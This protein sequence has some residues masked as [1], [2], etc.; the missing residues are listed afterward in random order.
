MLT[1]N[2]AH[3]L[4]DCLDSLFEVQIPDCEILVFDDGSSDNTP[5]VCAAYERKDQRVRTCRQP[6]N[7]GMLRNCAAALEAASGRY[8]SVIADDDSVLPGNFEKK[9][10]ILDAHPEVGLVYSLF[11][12]TNEQNQRVAM[13]LRSEYMPYSYVGG[14]HEFM[15]LLSG[16]YVP[17]PSVVVRHTL[18]QRL[19]GHDASMPSTLSDWD[20]W[21]R[22]SHDMATAF[23]REPLVNVR[24]HGGGVSSEQASDMALSMIPVWRKWLVEN[25]DPP[26]V[27]PRTWERMR[28]MFF[29]EVS[30]C[31]AN[32][33]AAATECATAFRHL[34]RDALANA[35]S[36]FA[37]L[38]R[39]L[40]IH[41]A[42]TENALVLAGPSWEQGHYGDDLRSLAAIQMP[43]ARI[44][45]EDV[46]WSTEQLLSPSIEDERLRELH[47][48]SLASA[49]RVVR[50]E[51]LPPPYLQPQAEG[52]AR[53]ARLLWGGNALPA[54]WTE[55][56]RQFDVVL[57]PNNFTRQR[58][59]E[60]NLPEDR[61]LIL[62]ICV[63]PTR[64]TAEG[65]RLELG[66]GRTFNFVSIL[67]WS[68]ESGWDVL[69]RAFVNTFRADEDVALNLFVR[70]TCG[71]SQEQIQADVHGLLGLSN[72]QARSLPVI[73]MT[74]GIT[75]NQLPAIFRAGQAYASLPRVEPTARRVCEAL[76]TGL[77]V[78][79]TA[80]GAHAEL[81]NE[82]NAFPV[83][84]RR[85]AAATEGWSDSVWQAPEWFEPDIEH[86]QAA[87]RQ[88]FEDHGSALATARAGRE[89][90]LHRFHPQAVA[91][92]LRNIASLS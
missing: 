35:S 14:R 7:L 28:A 62:P 81:L 88:A 63:D 3:M 70:S 53:M 51:D 55:T 34:E 73:R 71:R 36:H 85:S 48:T 42:E 13:P 87:M 5:E 15:D 75:E 31:C 68:A 46:H 59:I 77:P 19:G 16:N 10:A 23:I 37:R 21:L 50:I 65:P 56:L 45:L 12:A 64:F 9:V 80:C 92:C 41:M 60:A 2:R 47:W 83:S 84:C 89:L 57:I 43:D 24:Y 1:Y 17:G 20:L 49:K 18:W 26:V 33:V 52:S 74:L 32:D 58:A 38:S 79:T 11:Y 4:S 78:L 91:E 69:I 54:C 40:A 8:F 44:R 39:P 72:G 66:S 90:V 76:S 29:S 61:L 86:A 67:N 27:D 22:Y 30:R 6:T 82:R 25:P